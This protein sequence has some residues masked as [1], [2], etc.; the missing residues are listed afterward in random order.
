MEF[1]Y[2][3]R[4]ELVL[5]NTC[6]CFGLCCNPAHSHLSACIHPC[7]SP[8]K[9]IGTAQ[10]KVRLRYRY[11]EALLLDMSLLRSEKNIFNAISDILWFRLYTVCS[12][13]IYRRGNFLQQPIIHVPDIKLI[14]RYTQ[15]EIY[16]Y[17]LPYGNSN[18]VG[19]KIST[20]SFF[21]SVN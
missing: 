7:I 10:Y 17:F 5:S 16:N 12:K 1:N 9:S 19:K 4:T 3:L 20:K 18:F 2:Y 8:S 11:L 13:R 21:P 14:I 6:F 15:E